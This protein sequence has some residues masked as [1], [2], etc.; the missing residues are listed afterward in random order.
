MAYEDIFLYLGAFGPY[1]R[2]IYFLLCLTNISCALHKLAGVFLQAKIDHRCSLPFESNNATYQELPREL[3]NMTYPWDTRLKAWSSCQRLDGDFSDEYFI[4]NLPSNH[5]VYCDNGWIYDKTTYQSS[6]VIEWDL[7]CD[8][9]WLRATADSMFMLGDALGSVSFGFLS[10]K[11]GR[12]PIFFVALTM[13]LVAGFLVAVSPTYL[14]FMLSRFL[15]GITASGMFLVAFVIALEMVAP[16]KRVMAGIPCQLFFTSGYIFVTAFSYFINNWRIIPESA[17]WLLSNGREEEG[18]AVILKVARKN[19]VHIPTDV[20][21]GLMHQEDSN[22]N[23]FPQEQIKK[24]SFL[25]LL[26]YPVLRR[27]AFYI[28]FIW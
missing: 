2:Y 24:P 4:N 14:C 10:D 5:S 18:K 28:F 12:R 8:K 13:Q 11:F 9:A 25:D 17:R 15:V 23:I 22:G 19:Q 3:Y 27:R 1:Q 21:S 20:I 6:T 26:K 16:S 7:V